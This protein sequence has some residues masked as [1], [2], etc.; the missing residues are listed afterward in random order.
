MDHQRTAQ[1]P[2]GEEEQAKEIEKE[3][4]A[5][6]EAQAEEEDRMWGIPLSD[7]DPVRVYY[8]QNKLQGFT[9]P[10]D[11][12]YP[13]SATLND[14]VYLWRGDITNLSVDCIVNAANK[15]LL[16]GGGVD[17]AIHAAA[18]RGLYTECKTLNGA[19]T[20][21]TKLTGGHELPAK[22]VA[23]T[24]GPIY[25]QKR[26]AESED[27]LRSCYKGTLELCVKNGIRTVAFSG[28][29]TGV[30][31]YPLDDAASVA[32]DEVRKFL[33]GPDGDK[34]DAIIFTV[35]RP[36]DVASYENNLPAYF[37]PPSSNA[38]SDA[39]T[40][41]KAAE[42]ETTPEPSVEAQEAQA[43][44]QDKPPKASVEEGEK[45]E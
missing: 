12:V 42:S 44:C 5:E 30:Y 40:E 23:H 36:I 15:S 29:S 4:A 16:G 19:E 17:G 13:H 10:K 22:H 20:G 37:P 6:P 25:S 45:K 41:G 35:F 43:A 1:P 31:G 26:K 14:K 18:G 11:L 8:E 3:D 39:A 38:A 27:K 21:E 33:E 7:L 2:T 34:L 24:V 9:D 32:C 28:I